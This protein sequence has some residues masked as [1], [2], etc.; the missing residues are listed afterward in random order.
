MITLEEYRQ[1]QQ[2]VKDYRVCGNGGHG[3]G[4]LFKIEDTNHTIQYGQEYWWCKVC[5]EHIKN[6]W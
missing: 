1:A 6:D 4:K 5:Y 2:I 3:C